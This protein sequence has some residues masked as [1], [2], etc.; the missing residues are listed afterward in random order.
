MIIECKHC[1]APLDIQPNATLARCA[2]CGTTQRVKTA[3]TQFRQT[4]A[5]WHAPAQWTPPVQ[6]AARSVPLRFDHTK[7]VRKVVLFVI[8]ISVVTT[9]LPIAIVVIVMIAGAVASSSSSSKPSRTKRTTKQTST[10]KKSTK[11]HD[12]VGSGKASEVCTQAAA[13][14]RLLTP[15]S[16]ACDLLEKTGHVPA[17]RASL[18]SFK[19]AAKAQGLSCE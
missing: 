5:G 17:C 14:C 15:G 19:K 9:V 10:K 18:D 7:T 1:G 12:L 3:T 6:A 13:C 16:A 2:Y 4:P 8:I 11:A